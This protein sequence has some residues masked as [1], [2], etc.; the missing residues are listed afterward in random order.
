MAPLVATAFLIGLASGVHCVV[1]CGGI[2]AALGL[3]DPAAASR[4]PAAS[5]LRQLAYSAGRM[6]TYAT[7]GAVAGAVGGLGLRAASVLPVQ[8]LLVVA[9]N[10]LVI[11]LGLNLAGLSTAASFLDRLGGFLWRAVQRLGGRLAPARSLA[12]ALGAGLV[13]GFLP[14]G[15]VY[16]VLATAL[17]SGGAARG[18]LVM[19]AFGVG[20]LPNLLA[21][22]LAAETLRSL[23]RAPRVRMAAGLAVVILGLIG[24]ARIADLPEH[25]RHGLHALR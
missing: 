5:F 18:A 13:W 7:L 1:M 21:A 4:G 24:L 3:S 15:L 19:A 17:V 9:A 6:T 23:L 22:G 25:L 2:V 11:L 12:G 16:G 14:C 10:V 20:T 8:V